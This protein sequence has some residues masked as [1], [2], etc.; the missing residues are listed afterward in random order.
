MADSVLLIESLY[1]FCGQ[2]I[3]EG[4]L[5]V[6]QGPQPFIVKFDIYVHERIHSRINIQFGHLTA[7]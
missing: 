1:R 6:G 7:I 2:R 4:T 5:G 3:N